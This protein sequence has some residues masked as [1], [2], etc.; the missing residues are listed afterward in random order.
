MDTPDK[1]SNKDGIHGLPLIAGAAVSFGIGWLM[2]SGFRWLGTTAWPWIKR[3]PIATGILCVMFY[4]VGLLDEHYHF[5]NDTGGIIGIGELAVL[6]A[7]VFTTNAM[8][9]EG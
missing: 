9:R 7:V 2:V 6:L 3:H 8:S 1:P 4:S 5:T